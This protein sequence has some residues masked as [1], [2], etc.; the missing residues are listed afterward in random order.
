MKLF[1]YLGVSPPCAIEEH[2]ESGRFVPLTQ[3][4]TSEDLRQTITNLIPLLHAAPSV[5]DPIRYVVSELGRNVLSTLSQ[6]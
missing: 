5:A 6:R 4:R 2:E 1:D 3:I